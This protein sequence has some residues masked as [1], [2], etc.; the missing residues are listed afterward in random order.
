[1][2]VLR[3]CQPIRRMDL[4]FNLEYEVCTCTHSLFSKAFGKFKLLVLSGEEGFL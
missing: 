3:M 1:M 2:S 4:K